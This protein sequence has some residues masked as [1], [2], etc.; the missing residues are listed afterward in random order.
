M[1]FSHF[2]RVHDHIFIANTAGH[3][4]GFFSYYL[5]FVSNFNYIKLVIKF[6]KLYM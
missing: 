3:Y 1:F 6:E 2:P 4:T 5:Q